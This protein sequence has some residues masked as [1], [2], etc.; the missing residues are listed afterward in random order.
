MHVARDVVLQC[1]G[2]VLAE[3][4]VSAVAAFMSGNMETSRVAIT[5]SD[6]RVEV[7]R[8]VLLA[9]QRRRPQSRSR[10]ESTLSERVW[11]GLSNG[12]S[13]FSTV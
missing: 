7:R 3:R 10:T 6:Q 9:R 8:A 13:S 4:G 12:S 11:P 2:E 1:I 5:E